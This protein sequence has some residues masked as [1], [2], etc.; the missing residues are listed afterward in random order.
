MWGGTRPPH[1]LQSA[2]T[3]GFD[4]LAIID[5]HQLVITGANHNI[6][7]GRPKA[8]GEGIGRSDF[9]ACN[10][11]A[12]KEKTAMKKFVLFTALVIGLQAGSALAADSITNNYGDGQII[13]LDDGSVSSTGNP[14]ANERVN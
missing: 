7:A 9:P 8:A 5:V 2:Q 6:I 11:F 14:A 12:A 3:L 10:K 1:R 4:F 13:K